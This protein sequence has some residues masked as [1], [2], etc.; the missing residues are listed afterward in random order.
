[1]NYQNYQDEYKQKMMFLF[2]LST[3]IYKEFIIIDL[4]L[5][6][7]IIAKMALTDINS[8]SVFDDSESEQKTK[9]LQVDHLQEV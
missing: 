5:M 4:H 7:C 9:L 1:M 8:N 3:F 6:Q 2:V